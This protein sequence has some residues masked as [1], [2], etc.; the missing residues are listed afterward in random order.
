M[1]C[2]DS[3]SDLADAARA[4]SA[5]PSSSTMRDR[6]AGHRRTRRALARRGVER[7]HRHDAGVGRAEAL[8]D[9]GDAEALGSPGRGSARCRDRG[10]TRSGLSRSSSRRLLA[11]QDR[12]DGAERVEHGRARLVH[13][14]PELGR[15]ERLREGDRRRRPASAVAAAP[16]ALPWNSGVTARIVS[17]GPMPSRSMK[18]CAAAAGAA[19]AEEDALRLAGRARRVEQGRA[20]GGA[21]GRRRAARR[22]LARDQRRRSRSSAAAA[23]RRQSHARRPRE[24]R[25][26]QRLDVAGVGDESPA[27]RRGRGCSSARSRRAPG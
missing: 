24:L 21:R 20:V 6:H 16:Q 25:R 15:A 12:E 11:Q 3:I 7:R 14:R 4:G 19:V 17:S 5:A 13:E 1:R 18:C 9:V 23:E 26:G 22:T 27:A 8:G 2:G 10:S